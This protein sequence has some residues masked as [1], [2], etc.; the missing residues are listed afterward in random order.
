MVKTAIDESAIPVLEFC[1]LKQAI[2]FL[3]DGLKPITRDQERL[4]RTDFEAYGNS[5]ENK[6][7]KLLQPLIDDKFSLTGIDGHLYYCRMTHELLEFK[8]TG[9]RKPVSIKDI[10]A[11]R[12]DWDFGCIF[13][14]TL[15]GK[16]DPYSEDGVYISAIGELQIPFKELQE[17]KAT[18]EK[19]IPVVDLGLDIDFSGIT[20]YTTPY[21]EIMRN[22]I[23]KEG[24][25]A[26]NQSKKVSLANLI[27]REMKKKGL[28]ESKNL[29][30]AMAT[31]IRLPEYQKGK[32]RK[33]K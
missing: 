25:S 2:D 8:G 31:L 9:K 6:Y 19:E 17:Y 29:A 10:K 1:T 13:D 28:P 3:Y 11:G 15:L 12:I 30:N 5:V 4:F 23:I 33:L 20:S 27:E 22:V 7:E 26:D 16:Y 18:M 21:L 32:A 24:L 14:P